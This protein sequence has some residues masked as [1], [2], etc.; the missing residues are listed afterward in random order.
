MYVYIFNHRR[1]FLWL[2][3]MMQ[4]VLCVMVYVSVSEGSFVLW[5]GMTTRKLWKFAIRF[6]LYYAFTDNKINNDDIESTSLDIEVCH[7][8][9]VDTSAPWNRWK[10]AS[11]QTSRRRRNVRQAR[12][13]TC[14]KPVVQRGKKKSIVK[15]RCTLSIDVGLWKERH[16]TLSLWKE[17]HTTVSL[18]RERHTTLSLRRERHTT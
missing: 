7:S 1:V 13:I 17:R 2:I 12:T 14:A 10:W 8:A 5:Y 18:R 9:P 16:T 15:N 4:C 11:T 3:N 6:K